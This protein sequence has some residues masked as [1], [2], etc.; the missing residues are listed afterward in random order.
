MT[1]SR[2]R[3][4]AARKGSGSLSPAAGVV[5]A[6][7]LVALSAPP[8]HAQTFAERGFAD[9]GAFVYPIDA[10]NDTTKLVG[11]AL[12]R[13]ELF[14]KPA[15]WLRLSAGM[16]L[17]ANSHGQVDASWRVDFTDRGRLRPAVSVRRLAATIT[18]GPLTIDVGKQFIRWGK[19]DIVT[20]TDRFAPRDFINVVFNDFIAV[21]AARA[22]V[23]IGRDSFDAVWVPFMTPSRMPLLDQRWTPVPPESAG[24]PLVDAGTP[25]PTGSETGFRWSRTGRIDFSLSAFDGF[26]HLPDLVAAQAPGASLVAPVILVSRVYP[27]LRSYGGD[28][29]IPTKWFT[30]KGEAE[31]FSSPSATSDEYVLYVVQLER[32]TGEWVFAGGYA[33]EAVTEHRAL[34]SFSPDRGLTRSIV[35]R[36]AYTIDPNR[37]VAFDAAIRQNL[38]GAY[39]RG[40]YSQARGEHW[41]LT[42]SGV[43]IGGA[44]DDFL[45]QYRRDSYVSATMR[46]S[47]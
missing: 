2:C 15:D 44:S 27:P 32:Q 18:R 28:I 47:F 7:A 5:A 12:V 9:L 46:Y 10:P 43:A 14:V 20:P 35:G 21:T 25:Y 13:G 3:R 19:T 6:L 37:S 4:F 30:I 1:T 23:Q 11:D 29:A 17:R 16:D 26:N 22:V 36:A 45:G 41:R 8:L 42:L 33:G 34:L 39:V 38:Q 40:E 24:I 31:Y